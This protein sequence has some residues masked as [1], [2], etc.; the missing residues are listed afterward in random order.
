MTIL[1]FLLPIFFTMLFGVFDALQTA[2]KDYPYTNN[3]IWNYMQRQGEGYMNWYKGGNDIYPP[4]DP[5]HCDFWHTMKYA[6][7][8]C[9]SAIALSTVL[10]SIIYPS[11]WL[12]LYALL[13]G[14]EG[15]TFQF[16]YSYW[17]HTDRTFKDYINR[18]L[19]TLW[20]LPFKIK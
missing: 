18:T 7:T 1:L 3:K 12:L 8:F 15:F 5:F 11:Y 14:V 20:F 13:Y 16:F 19:T 10:V 6:W 9:I 4:Y 2:R 17:L